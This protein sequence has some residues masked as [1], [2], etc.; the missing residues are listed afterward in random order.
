VSLVYTQ[1]M[2][3]SW[4]GYLN[5][6]THSRTRAHIKVSVALLR[7]TRIGAALASCIPSI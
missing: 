7:N 4:N 3:S 5:D 1:T 6:S 2:A